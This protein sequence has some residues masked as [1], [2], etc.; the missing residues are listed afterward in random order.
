MI[1]I[2]RLPIYLL[3][4]SI[5]VLTLTYLSDLYNM[6]FEDTFYEGYVFAFKILLFDAIVL[7][8][9]VVILI[10]KNRFELKLSC[11]LTVLLQ[12]VTL[13]LDF[14]IGALYVT[15]IGILSAIYFVKRLN[16][17]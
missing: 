4:I 9:L 15:L 10:Q 17:V 12:Q 13:F 8:P 3:F 5:V 1:K 2:T 16:E 7:I 6:Y 11:V 14:K